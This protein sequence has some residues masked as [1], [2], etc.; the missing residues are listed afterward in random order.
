MCTLD[1][2]LLG[3]EGPNAIEDKEVEGERGESDEESAGEVGSRAVREEEAQAEG[4]D[5]D[6]EAEKGEQAEG[7]IEVASAGY[8]GREGSA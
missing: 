1:D 5:E 4:Y 3:N 6:D 7:P 2:V 8:E